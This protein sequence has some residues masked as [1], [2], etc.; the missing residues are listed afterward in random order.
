MKSYEEQRRERLSEAIFDYI[1]D[2]N[3]SARE[4]YLDIRNEIEST[5]Q[6]HR[7][8]MNKCDELMDHLNGFRDLSLS[9]SETNHQVHANSP[10]ND[11]WTQQYHKD[12]L[13][14]KKND[15]I[16][17]G[18]NPSSVG[19]ATPSDWSDFWGDDHIRLTDC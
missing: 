15:I 9:D 7:T 8:Y 19:V 17:F 18:K 6:Y 4:L 3:T 10:Y 2:D 5:Q 1:Q 11:G 14:Q 12:L 16:T 13:E